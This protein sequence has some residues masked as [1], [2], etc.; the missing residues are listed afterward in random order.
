MK[1]DTFYFS[2]DYNARND[3]KIKALLRKHGL[4]GYGIFW[5]I[6]EDLY[7]NA[8]A[9]PTDYESIAF[10]LRVNEDI[11]NSI[12]LDFDL[13]QVDG[14]LFGSLSIQKRLDERELKSNTARD[15]ANKR[16]KGNATVM[17]PHSKGNAIKERK[18]KDIKE[19]EIVL[20]FPF[21][22]SDFVNAW[23]TIIKE[24]KWKKK[25]LNALQESLNILKG[26]SEPVAIAMIKKAIEGNWQGLYPIKTEQVIQTN[27]SSKLMSNLDPLLFD[28]Y[29][30]YVDA[31]RAED[32]KP[33][34]AELYDQLK[35]E[36]T[37]K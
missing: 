2:H 20:E 15:N 7:N 37:K 31:C 6:V 28:T 16:W 17:Q 29:K 36:S 3:P 32:R 21:F 23:E 12:V 25:S 22:S 30:D 18:G 33:C 14:N 34:Y 35:Y 5:S 24:P 27:A 9:L 10:D 26:Y 4:L 19:K 13:F 11:I 8:N 1:Q